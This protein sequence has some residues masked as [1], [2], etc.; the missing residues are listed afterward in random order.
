MLP[1]QQIEE[2]LSFSHLRAVASWA[3]V[4]L[5]LFERDYGI[6]GTFRPHRTLRS[7]PI[8]TGY[9]LD[10][11]IKAS[12][13]YQLSLDAVIYD[14]EVKTYND[15]VQRRLEDHAIPCI[16][17]LKLLPADRTQ[18]I[19]VSEV[20]L[21]LAGGC[22]WEYLQGNLSSNRKSVRIQIPRTQQLT[23]EALLMLLDRVRSREWPC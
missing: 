18:W 6:D 3:G 20:G 12:T 10:F 1:E 17:L 23:P 16:L 8:P 5:E 4:S 22:Y 9:A 13:R 14:L 11:Q 15:L 21:L 19:E 2:L 7:R